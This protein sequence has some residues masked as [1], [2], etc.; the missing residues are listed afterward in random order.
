[1]NGIQDPLHLYMV[2]E[3]PKKRM[4]SIVVCDPPRL[5]MFLFF[6]LSLSCE[7]I[8]A[9]ECYETQKWAREIETV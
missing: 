7:E 6:A 2:H 8:F 1:M 9:S 3:S 5:S 4:M